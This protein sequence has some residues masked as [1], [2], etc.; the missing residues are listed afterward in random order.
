MLTEPASAEPWDS[1]VGEWRTSIRAMLLI[2]AMSTWTER[3]VLLSP[4]V[5]ARL[6]P[7]SVIGTL[8]D[9]TPLIEMPRA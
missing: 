4:P 5:L 1:G 9:G 7:S 3:P 6:K 8:A 2:D